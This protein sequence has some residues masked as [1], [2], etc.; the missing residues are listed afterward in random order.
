M[1][2]QFD[3]DCLKGS[4]KRIAAVLAGVGTLVQVPAVKDALVQLVTAHPHYA[5]LAAT[6]VS[7]WTLIHNPQVEKILGLNIP[8][9]GS[10]PKD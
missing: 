6:A 7:L 10:D 2:I 1:K 4:T 3:S 8:A 9:G 5:T